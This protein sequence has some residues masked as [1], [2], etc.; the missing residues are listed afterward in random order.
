MKMIMI[1]IKYWK[2]IFVLNCEKEGAEQDLDT[3]EERGKT[4]IDENLHTH[5]VR[6]F[7][8]NTKLL[9]V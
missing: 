6:L 9:Q 4:L 1:I 2:Y 8:K 3:G 7:L 5:F